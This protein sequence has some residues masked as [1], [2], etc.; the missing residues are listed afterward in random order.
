M[1]ILT[2]KTILAGGETALP[3]DTPSGRLDSAN[4][5]P[6]VGALEIGNGT[7]TYKGSGVALSPN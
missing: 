2:T 7:S 1:A 4:A 3:A 6:F 5:F